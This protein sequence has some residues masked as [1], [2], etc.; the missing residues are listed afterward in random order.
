M[1]PF[2]LHVP[3]SQA[4]EWIRDGDLLL[5]RR[6]GLIAAF[7]RGEHS[8][9][10]LA[11]WWSETLC[12]LEVRGRCGG[13]VVTLASQVARLPGQ[14]DVFLADPDD[15]WPEFDRRQTVQNMLQFAGTT[16]GYRN[17]FRVALRHIPGMRLILPAKTNDET[18]NP[19]SPICSQ[20]C[21]MATRLG[22]GVDPVPQLADE[23][24]EPADLARSPFYRYRATLVPDT[25]SESL[26]HPNPTMTERPGWLRFLTVI[27]LFVLAL[28]LMAPPCQ[29]QPA[30]PGGSCRV[31]TP[32]GGQHNPPIFDTTPSIPDRISERLTAATA[33]V[34]NRLPHGETA[35]GSGVLV[36]RDARWGWVLSCDHLFRD[37]VGQVV[38]VLRSATGWRGY[39][40]R[41]FAR[42]SLADLALIGIATPENA[43]ISL[44][45]TQPSPGDRVI[46]AGYGRAGRFHAVSGQVLGYVG[47]QIQESRETLQITGAAQEGDS[48]G[49]IVDA[50]GQLVAIL[51]GTDGVRT[52]GTYCGRIRIFLRN[53]LPRLEDQGPAGNSGIPAPPDN[54]TKKAQ[55]KPPTAEQVAAPQDSSSG[56]SLLDRLHRRLET[57]Q[58]RVEAAQSDQQSLSDRLRHL[59]GALGIVTDLRQRLEKAEQVVGRENVRAVIRETA[60][61][62]IKE[63]GTSWLNT[64]LPAVFTALGWTGPPSLALAFIARLA[65]RILE[66]RLRAANVVQQARSSEEQKTTGLEQGEKQ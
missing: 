49:P 61:D 60:A 46:L 18:S 44:A 42:D 7:G 66:R 40:G 9:A 10:A 65:L 55:E 47:A 2:R 24:T 59:E 63:R 8:H 12:C 21:V 45:E 54:I 1:T 15:R 4:Q 62:L 39:E 52:L 48:G 41:V 28:F 20:A 53:L 22:G 5:F 23:L 30:C 43:P 34:S 31:P 36:A 6:R 35:Y 17:L 25:E 29:A 58:G 57:L 37:G 14:I 3:L 38:V 32:I 19:F 51:W 64:L 33:R 16:Y 50:N 11:G 27:G 26:P 56:D 13:R